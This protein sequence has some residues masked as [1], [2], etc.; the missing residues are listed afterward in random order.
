MV[1]CVKKKQT[2]DRFDLLFVVVPGRLPATLSVT[3]LTKA[4]IRFGN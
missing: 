4:V 2:K 1:I 3:V